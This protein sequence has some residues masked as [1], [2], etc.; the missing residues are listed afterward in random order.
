MECKK[1]LNLKKCNCTYSC[2]RHGVCCDCIAYHRGSGEIPACY[3]PNEVE[4]GYNRSIDNFI[5][6]VSER[7]VDYLR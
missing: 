2:S 3:F 1:E 4:I 7:G 5:R 6:I